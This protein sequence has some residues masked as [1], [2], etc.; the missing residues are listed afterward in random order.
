MEGSASRAYFLPESNFPPSLAGIG[1]NFDDCMQFSEPAA[2]QV[3]SQFS[4]LLLRILGDIANRIAESL[5]IENGFAALGEIRGRDGQTVIDAVAEQFKKEFLYSLPAMSEQS[6][7]QVSQ[8][9]SQRF[10]EIVPEQINMLDN[11][12]SRIG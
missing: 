12:F 4:E 1:F 11:P 3:A 10:A 2:R 6:K 8:R 9:S 5:Q 7:T